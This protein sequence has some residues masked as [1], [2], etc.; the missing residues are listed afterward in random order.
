M[1]GHTKE[2]YMHKCRLLINTCLKKL[3]YQIVRHTPEKQEQYAVLDFTTE[4]IF[5]ALPRWQSRF[6]IDG[7][8]YGGKAD[9]RTHRVS[10]LNDAG[11]YRHV[12]FTGKTVIEFG[13]LEGGNSIIMEKLN[14]KS[15]TA[16][17]GHREN[18]IRCCVIKNLFQ[19]N[20]TT[21]YF[22][23]V[24]RATVEKYGT[25]DLGFI[26]GLLYHLEKPHLFL[27][28]VSTMTDAIIVSTHY[29]DEESPSPDAAVMEIHHNGVAYQGKEF[30][31]GVGP[32]SGLQPVSFWP[33][34]KDLLNMIKNSGYK[35]ITVINDL[36]D[37]K[38]KYRLIYLV[39]KKD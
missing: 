10:M 36:I 21:F 11:L 34:K 31:E 27:S 39:A 14:A 23:D 32:S 38:T 2:T 16:L 8:V 33:F 26:A 28:H 1:Y 22:D 15:I 25:Y 13:P 17:E 30:R 5:N 35:K 29:A 9:Y 4:E 24:M 7:N 3:G 18:F 20:R 6:E 12:D 37:E 19:L